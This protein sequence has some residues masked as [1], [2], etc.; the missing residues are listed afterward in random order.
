M[1]LL[2]MSQLLARGQHLVPRVAAARLRG[3]A[4]AVMAAI[5]DHS[6]SD[7]EI[8]QQS[9]VRIEQQLAA[10]TPDSSVWLG[11]RAQ[12]L[13]TYE[14]IRGGYLLSL[15]DYNEI[16]EYR[17][18]FGIDQLGQQV[19]SNVD[20]DEMFYLTSMRQGIAS[21]EHA[22]SRRQPVFRQIRRQLDA[23]R[24]TNSFPFVA[25]RLLLGELEQGHRWQAL[26]R[27]RFL[28]WQL[29][30]SAA[31]GHPTDEVPAN[32][33]TGLHFII[34]LRS[35]RVLVDAIDPQRREPPIVVRRFHGESQS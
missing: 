1:R 10:W 6:Y 25:E 11:E 32:P 26:D 3:E 2:Q 30:L 12:G 35:D 34:E 23:M 20:V 5:I 24:E 16:R 9:L 31:A 33:L 17:D 14:M 15:L 27:A 28:G 19:L 22:F 4:L 29:A 7:D 13:H 8:Q 18:E 21:C